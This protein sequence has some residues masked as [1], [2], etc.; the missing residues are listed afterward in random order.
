VKK[1]RLASVCT[2]ED[3]NAFLP[4][5]VANYNARFAKPAANPK[6]LHRLMTNS[7]NLDEAFNWRVE[8]TLSQALTLQ[9]DKV[10]FILEPTGAAQ[11]AIGKRVTVYD[12]P[13][14]RLVIRHDGVDLP[15]RTFDKIRKVNQA[16]I[17]EN[18][19]LGVS[20]RPDPAEPRHA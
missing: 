20:A 16:A 7:D 2:M 8:R 3:G 4:G 9:Y 11:A 6:D 17:T 10:M 5:F 13:D 1:L 19:R 12:Y 18:K 15:Y 14:G